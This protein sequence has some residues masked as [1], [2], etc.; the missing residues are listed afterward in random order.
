MNK[1]DCVDCKFWTGGDK[2][3]GEC[4]GDRPMIQAGGYKG[5]WPQTKH[6]DWCGKGALQGEEV[7]GRPVLTEPVVGVAGIGV[8]TWDDS[9]PMVNSMVVDR[10]AYNQLRSELSIYRE[11]VADL[12]DRVE[13]LKAREAELLEAAKVDDARIIKLS[14]PQKDEPDWVDQIAEKVKKSKPTLKRKP[15]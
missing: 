7:G 9:T 6:H 13:H 11:K 5:E 4:R 15:K 10:K 8:N 3:V 14:K 1:V 12:Q 2:G